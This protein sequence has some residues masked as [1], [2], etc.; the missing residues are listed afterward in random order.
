MYLSPSLLYIIVHYCTT[1]LIQSWNLISFLQGLLYLKIARCYQSLEERKQGIIY[2]YKGK[3]I[4][5][6]NGI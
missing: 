5:I 4:F 6:K 3:V 2:F 1:R